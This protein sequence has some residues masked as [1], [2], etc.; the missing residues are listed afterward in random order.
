[1]RDS[2]LVKLHTIKV[3]QMVSIT[4]STQMN[5]INLSSRFYQVCLILQESGKTKWVIKYKIKI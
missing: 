1:M 3:K 5:G 2:R 4:N